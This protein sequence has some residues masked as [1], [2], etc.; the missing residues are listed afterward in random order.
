MNF[1][2]KALFHKKK[3]EFVPNI[4]SMIVEMLSFLVLIIAHQF[5]P[6]IVG[7][8]TEK[9][10]VLTLLKRI[11]NFLRVCITVVMKIICMQIKQRFANLW[12][13]ITYLDINFVSEA[14]QKILQK[15]K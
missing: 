2:R 14:Y 1:S 4:L 5:I 6:V 8:T 10:L 15:M 11:Q 12:C 7:A 9:I 3:I 13:M